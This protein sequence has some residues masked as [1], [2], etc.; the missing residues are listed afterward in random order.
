MKKIDSK[1]IELTLSG[2]VLKVERAGEW[3][4]LILEPK[5]RVSFTTKVILKGEIAREAL[6]KISEG[7]QIVASGG[8]F[9]VGDGSLKLFADICMVLED[10]NVV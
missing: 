5:P 9:K 7:K 1:G 3:L 8:L 10:G 4:A 6:R 2:R